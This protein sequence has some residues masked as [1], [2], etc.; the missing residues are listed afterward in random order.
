M[1]VRDSQQLILN[2]EIKAEGLLQHSPGQIAPGKQE[3]QNPPGCRPGT[4][5]AS[6]MLKHTVLTSTASKPARPTHL[7]HTESDLL[8]ACSLPV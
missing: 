7:H 8:Q 5:W 3:P 1:T 4:G 6:K 2:Y